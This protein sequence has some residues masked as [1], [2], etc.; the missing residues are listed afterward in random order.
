MHGWATIDEFVGIINTHDGH[1][2]IHSSI[3]NPESEF[4]AAFESGI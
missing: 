4:L 1:S 3:V 2:C